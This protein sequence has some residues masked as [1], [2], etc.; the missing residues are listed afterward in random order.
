MTATSTA[1]STITTTTLN[2]NKASTTGSTISASIVSISPTST[3][4]AVSNN[5]TSNTVS[6]AAIAGGVGGGVA[7][8]AIVAGILWFCLRRR[9]NKNKRPSDNLIFE[10]APPYAATI[11]ESFAKVRGPPMSELDSTKNV[12]VVELPGHAIADSV[13]YNRF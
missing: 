13:K 9:R 12:G 11:T 6:V 4:S 7:A 2:S 5:S 8:V 10:E 1:T 3:S